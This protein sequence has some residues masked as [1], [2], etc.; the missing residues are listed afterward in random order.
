M[1]VHEEHKQ[2]GPKEIN[3]SVIIV[4]S[5]RFKEIQ[6]GGENTDKTIPLI[7]KILEN[8][9]NVRLISSEIVADDSEQLSKALDTRLK[10]DDLHFILFSG[11][12]GL[13]P[14]DVTYETIT[15]R[16]EKELMGF[17]ELFRTLSYEEIGSSA[18]LSRATGGKIGNKGI[19][20]LP[21]SPKAVELALKKL[22]LPEVGHIIS[23]INK[24]E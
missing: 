13:S 5:S 3:V 1:K 17:G 16:L 18:M 15:P 4:S 21:G 24:K 7:N 12:T 9:P 22:L 23:Q 14:K 6:E 11:G 19:F 20:L 2:K 8:Y 10:V